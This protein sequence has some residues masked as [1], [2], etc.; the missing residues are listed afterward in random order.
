MLSSY[1]K[2]VEEAVGEHE[3]V[4]PCRPPN[5][6]IWH[7]A[8]RPRATCSGTGFASGRAAKWP[9]MSSFTFSLTKT[10]GA[11][12]LG[13]IAT[14]HGIVRTPAFMPVGTQATIKGV[15]LPAVRAAGADIVLGNTYHL[16]LRPGAERIAGARR[17]AR[18]HELA[19]SD[20]DRLRRLPGHV[21]V[22]TAQ[23]RRERR[24]VPLAHRRRDGR[25]DAGARH[26]DAEP[27]RRRHRDAARRM[28]EA[29]GDAR[30][31]RARDA[32]VAALGRALQ[33]RLRGR[34]A[35]QGAVRHR[36]GRRRCGA[37]ARKRARAR[38]H[39]LS[40]LRHRRACG[41]R[42]AGGDAARWSRRPRRRCPP[43]GRAT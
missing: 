2:A 36:A 27:A 8:R 6:V 31:D 42:A 33:A 10:D 16:M 32:A 38:R 43:T 30:R 18:V 1:S 14:A 35:G 25:A 3:V 21:A 37:A 17:P 34:G 13:E 7:A 19:A 26:R 40:R 39:R 15:H 4:A 5:F 23:A 12:R 29:A 28:P 9:R 11:A 24:H 41:R 20:P 22:G